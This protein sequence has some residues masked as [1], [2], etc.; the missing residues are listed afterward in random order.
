VQRVIRRA[1]DESFISGFRAV[2]LIGMALALASAGTALTLTGKSNL[3]SR[4]LPS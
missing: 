1:V 4:H 2:M 3:G